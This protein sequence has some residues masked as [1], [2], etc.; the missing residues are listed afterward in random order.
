MT[1]DT[2]SNGS[3]SG[4]SGSDILIFLHGRFSVYRTL[5]ARKDIEEAIKSYAKEK[6]Y[7]KVRIIPGDKGQIGQQHDLT[8][9]VNAIQ[10]KG[11]EKIDI[12]GFSLG[13]ISAFREISRKFHQHEKEKIGTLVL[14]GAPEVGNHPIPGV[15]TI[16]IPY[17]QGVEHMKMVQYFAKNSTKYL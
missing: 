11:N 3:K 1:S 15:K 5:E 7:K 6:G 8:V 17:I 13:G 4:K 12:V 14:I 16:H 2:E 9:M 10:P